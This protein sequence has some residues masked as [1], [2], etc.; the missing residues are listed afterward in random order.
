LETVSV[1]ALEWKASSG[2]ASKSKFSSF[3]V[4]KYSRGRSQWRRGGSKW[5]SEGSRV[6]RPM[7]PESH[8]FDWWGAGSALKKNMSDPDPQ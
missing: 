3:T 5:S 7:G 6:C 1:S 2:S 4:S 8:H